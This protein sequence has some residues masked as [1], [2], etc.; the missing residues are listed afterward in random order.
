MGQG[1]QVCEYQTRVIN[2]NFNHMDGHRRGARPSF[3]KL[4]LSSKRIHMPLPV[5]P[6]YILSAFVILLGL[7][8]FLLI[9]LR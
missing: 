1:R 3:L 5:A 8:N 7:F 4:L 2:T 6:Q 9:R